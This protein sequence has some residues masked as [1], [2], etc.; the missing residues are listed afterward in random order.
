[1][2]KGF[3]R[4]T[5]SSAISTATLAHKVIKLLAAIAKT[6]VWV[7]LEGIPSAAR[8]T[9][10]LAHRAD[11]WLHRRNVAL[12]LRDPSEQA[13]ERLMTHVVRPQVAPDPEAELEQIYPAPGANAE[14]RLVRMG[15]R[16]G[17]VALTPAAE[18]RL[19]TEFRALS[20]LEGSRFF[21]QAYDIC[22]VRDER[23]PSG[24]ALCLS[25]EFIEGESLAHYLKRIEAG[26]L[27]VEPLDAV[28]L[29]MQLLYALSVAQSAGWVHRDV[30]PRNV[31][32]M[33]DGRVRLVDLGCA[34]PAAECAN[35]LHREKILSLGYQPPESETFGPWGFASDVYS[36][37]A[38]C[39]RMLYGQVAAPTHDPSPL[40]QFLTRGMAVNPQERY[41]NAQEAYRALSTVAAEMNLTI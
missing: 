30:H 21:P 20:S 19:L 37:C 29:L 6:V 3:Y 11:L 13:A 22:R 24:E 15:S 41:R 7:A 1:M 9:R 38:I 14:T 32:V 5:G 2:A 18:A 26:G 39:A 27:R 40:G 28:G 35:G 36:A 17:K 34:V 31:I 10:L 33:A 23:A 8:K 25:E 16:V 4:G 12:P